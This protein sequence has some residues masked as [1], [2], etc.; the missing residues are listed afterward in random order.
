MQKAGVVEK[1]NDNEFTGE[2]GRLRD[3]EREIGNQ[4]K[5]GKQVLDAMHTLAS[6]QIVDDLTELGL[7]ASEMPRY[8]EMWRMMEELVNNELVPN[9][10]LYM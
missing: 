2:E 1:T 3:A 8:K 10:N 5:Q 9:A 4:Q 7:E 6:S